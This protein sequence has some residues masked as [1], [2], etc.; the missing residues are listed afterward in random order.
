MN[1]FDGGCAAEA[2]CRG[3][4][5]AGRGGGATGAAGSAGRLRPGERG[6]A[7]GGQTGDLCQQAEVLGAERP[8]RSRRDGDRR[9]LGRQAA[10][11]G[12]DGGEAKPGKKGDG[13]DTDDEAAAC[14]VHIPVI[15]RGAA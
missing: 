4:A 1:P 10:A 13:G 8:I 5:A 2:A 14:G 3:C 11:I 12:P 6:V 15:G 7:L 9:G